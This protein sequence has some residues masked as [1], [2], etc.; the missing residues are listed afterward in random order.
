MLERLKR[1]WW[2]ARARFHE[3]RAA[4]ELRRAADNV[5]SHAHDIVVADKFVAK[6][7]GSAR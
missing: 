7:K 4:R 3:K 5:R 6:L 1:F 2:D